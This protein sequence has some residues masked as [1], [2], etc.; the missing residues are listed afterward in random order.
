MYQAIQ[1]ILHGAGAI[2]GATLGGFLTDHVGWRMCFLAQIPSCV[3]SLVLAGLFLKETPLAND[4]TVPDRPLLERLDLV[5]AGLL[6]FGLVF[7]LM[8]MSLGSDTTWS[9]PAVLAMFAASIITL[10]IFSIQEHRCKAIPVLPL[11]LLV[12]TQKVAMLLANITIGIIAYGVSTT[13]LCEL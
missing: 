6:F 10:V 1:N 9:N 12:G 8:A 7:Q 3:I 11:R 13:S 5:G 4:A 2:S